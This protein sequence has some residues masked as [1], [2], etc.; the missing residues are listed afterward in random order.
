[1]GHGHEGNTHNGFEASAL[2][3]VLQ[4]VWGSLLPGTAQQQARETRVS[5]R[6]PAGPLALLPGLGGGRRGEEL[7]TGKR[8][9]SRGGATPAVG[10]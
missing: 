4:G 7:R 10:R 1:M 9:G 2:T 5:T 3:L 6:T 8:R